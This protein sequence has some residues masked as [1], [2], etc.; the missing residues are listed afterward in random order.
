MTYKSRPLLDTRPDFNRVTHGQ[1][2]D[3]TLKRQGIGAG[4]PWKA[5]NRPKRKIKLPFL[6]ATKA[7]WRTFR[8]F[9]AARRGTQ[10]GFWLPLWLTDYE[11][12]VHTAADNKIRIP[13]VGLSSIFIAADQFAFVALID[14]NQLEPLEIANIT[15]L[16]GGDEQL[17]LTTNIAGTFSYQE[18][19]C[20]G[21]IYGR[22]ADGLISYEYISDGVIRADIDFI[23]LPREYPFPAVT[24]RPILLYQFQRGTQVWRFTNYAQS[25]VV[26]DELW[27]ADNISNEEIGFGLEM[28]GEAVTINVQTDRSDHPLRYY[29]QRAAIEK[30]LVSIFETDAATLTYDSTA[31]VYAGEIGEIQFGE[32]GQITARLPSIF[33]IGENQAPA[34]QTTRTC[35]LRTYDVN[36]G[37]NEL[38]FTTA[39][40]VT[41]VGADYVEALEFGAKVAASGDPNWFALGKVKIGSE[42]RMCTGGSG[43]RLY[44]NLPFFSVPTI[45]AA[46][47]ATA[48]DD[49]RIGT[50]LTKF[51]NVVRHMGFSYMPNKNPQLEGILNPQPS[52]GKKS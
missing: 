21:M 39:G 45:G 30:T 34:I 29:A 8:D 11:S 36:C 23:E 18:V 44:L 22:F 26:G 15:I 43:N 4:T 51:N 6:F 20:C 19:I 32:N 35:A 38:D 14:R 16:G 5:T 48:G 28:V 25:V 47:S 31:P 33:R 12:S 52:G 37:L 40:F 9:V 3:A 41:V 49:K 50:C 46:I 42:V 7:E 27:I 13:P 17:N 10:Q 1:L 24:S 2:D